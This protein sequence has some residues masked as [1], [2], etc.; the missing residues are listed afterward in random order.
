[1]L[2]TPPEIHNFHKKARKLTF[3]VE[4]IYPINTGALVIS[5]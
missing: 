5:S 4:S 3:V 2:L 1:M